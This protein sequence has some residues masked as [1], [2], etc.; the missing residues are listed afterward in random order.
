MK[1]KKLLT[2]LALIFMLST[3][4]CDKKIENDNFISN[5]INE[6]NKNTNI[7]EI[8]KTNINQQTEVQPKT[9][10]ITMKQISDFL[11]TKLEHYPLSD[12]FIE[13]YQQTSGGY[14][15][16]AKKA[17][18]IV[19]K[20]MHEPNQKW[21]FFESWLYPSIDDGTL[22]WDESAKSRVYSKLLCPE[23]L[24]WIYEACGV[25]PNKVREAKKIAEQ[26]KVA[27]T[28]VSTIAKNMRAIV[29]W[30]DLEAGIVEYLN[31]VQ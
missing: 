3:T 1:N 26:G 13:R 31:N 15:D 7:S 9:I 4:G 29:S 6:E 5:K 11:Q 8:I 28:N 12:E 22:T 19:D 27:K 10:T 24:L 25:D 23:L 21:H 20:Q 30:E 18:L 2:L 16:N 17:G 14:I